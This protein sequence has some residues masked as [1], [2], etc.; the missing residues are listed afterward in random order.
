MTISSAMTTAVSALQSQSKA[1]AVIA[2]NLANSSTTGYK[3]T[4]TSFSSMVTQMHVGRTHYNGGGVTA[5]A[6]QNVSAQG[7][8]ENGTNTT[9]LALDGA[10]MF[11]VRYGSG[12]DALFFTRNGEFSPDANGNLVNNNYY[13][14]GWPTDESGR[15]LGNQSSA[16][17]ERVNINKN[18]STVKASSKAKINADLGPATKVG[19][20]STTS[21]EVYD[22]LGTLHTVVMNWKKTGTATW[23][24]GFTSADG[25]T[26]LGTT[27]LTF[28]GNGKLTAPNPPKLTLPFKWANGSADSSI[29]VDISGLTQTFKDSGIS[30]A[31]AVTDGRTGGK[32]LGVSVG[33]DGTVTASYDNGQSVP[34]FKVPVATF[35]N[36][37]GLSPL[38]GGIYQRSNTSGNFSLHVAGTDGTAT[39]KGGKLESSTVDTANEL[40]R[41]IVAQQAYSAASQVINSSKSMYDALI[42]VVR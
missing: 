15:V 4:S 3:T 39:V 13:L 38:S 29:D 31:S 12:G 1:L 7:K 8:I 19:D 11:V 6:R 24:L 30:Q 42:A 27:S 21:M 23:D 40:T 9:D 5:S 18:N 25:T 22:S 33:A 10:G 35:A 16:A 14:M 41:M 36:Y 28:D 32:L 26:T 20:S 17:L 37:D 34:I 2:N